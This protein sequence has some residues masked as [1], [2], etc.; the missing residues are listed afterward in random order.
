MRKRLQALV[1]ILQD[2]LLETLKEVMIKRYCGLVSPLFVA[3]R[4]ML[5]GCKVECHPTMVT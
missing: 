4:R 5:L 1:E 3:I 2:S